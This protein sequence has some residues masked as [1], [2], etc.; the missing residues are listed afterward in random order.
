MIKVRVR[1]EIQGELVYQKARKYINTD[2]GIEGLLLIIFEE[3]KYQEQH[4]C[5]EF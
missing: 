3:F 4:D 1:E 5:N 2:G